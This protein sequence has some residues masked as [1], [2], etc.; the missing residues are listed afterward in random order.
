MR[1]RLRRF[2]RR[3]LPSSCH[4][5]H[6]EHRNPW[7]PHRQQV[8]LLVYSNQARRVK[9]HGGH[10]RALVHLQVLPQ[11]LRMLRNPICK[12][13]MSGLNC[14]RCMTWQRLPAGSRLGYNPCSNPHPLQLPIYITLTPIPS[15]QIPRQQSHPNS[16][17]IGFTNQ[18]NNLR[19]YTAPT[20]LYSRNGKYEHRAT[21][22]RLVSHQTEHDRYSPPPPD[23]RRG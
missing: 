5:G 10:Q 23:S 4:Q 17:Q 3:R 12:Y 14:R 6:Q 15:T 16:C 21:A 19:K 1:R 2:H 7:H 13:N 20:L 8:G 11:L 9:F 22:A 18:N